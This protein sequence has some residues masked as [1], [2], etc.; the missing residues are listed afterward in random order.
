M[1]KFKEKTKFTDNSPNTIKKSEDYRSGDSEL[2]DIEASVNFLFDDASL[3]G[4]KIHRNMGI[5]GLAF[6]AAGVLFIAQSP[7][8]NGT[9]IIA[10]A[11]FIFAIP[12]F[13]SFALFEDCVLIKGQK[14]AKHYPQIIKMK[15]NIVLSSLAYVFSVFGWIL[16]M[17]EKSFWLG[18]VTIFSIVL[19]LVHH[20]RLMDKFQE[21]FERDD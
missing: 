15:E 13:Y 21:S 12:L 11:L 4:I 18:V 3:E 5:S 2:V 14:G 1:S 8:L 17:F 19:G 16:I 7:E 10:V 9:S 6:C 20:G